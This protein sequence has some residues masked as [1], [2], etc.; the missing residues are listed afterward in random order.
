[1]SA[2]VDAIHRHEKTMNVEKLNASIALS[3]DATRED[4]KVAKFDKSTQ[5]DFS[6]WKQLAYG[7]Q[8]SRPMSLAYLPRQQT[9][10]SELSYSTHSSKSTLHPVQSEL[11]LSPRNRYNNN[12]FVSVDMRSINS[13]SSHSSP[14]SNNH[15][16]SNNVP[17]YSCC[18]TCAGSQ[19]P[20][21]PTPPSQVDDQGAESLSWRRLHMSRAKLKATATTSE[22]LSGFAMVSVYIHVH[23]HFLLL[24]VTPTYYSLSCLVY[25][26]RFL[27]VINS[28][29]LTIHSSYTD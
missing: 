27:R 15:I 5:S 3:S 4:A 9:Q 28:C 17:C 25:K 20:P 19:I 8:R 1:M 26:D 2:L 11:I 6:T 21:P 29:E 23:D 7:A 18:C 10:S 22:L 14:H 12:R 13:L 24:R 16:F